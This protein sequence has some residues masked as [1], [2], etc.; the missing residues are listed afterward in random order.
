MT[1]QQFEEFCQKVTWHWAKSYAKTHP[2]WY[3]RRDEVGDALFEEAV[4]FLR[5]HKIVRFFYSTPFG[6][7]DKDEY[8][9]W[10]MGNP[11][12]ETTIINRAIR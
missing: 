7:Y 12:E 3:C 11:I 8:T 2:H 5:E 4:K 10:T 6:Y 9:Y 1:E